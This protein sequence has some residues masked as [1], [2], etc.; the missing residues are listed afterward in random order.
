MNRKSNLIDS[1]ESSSFN[2]ESLQN[3]GKDKGFTSTKRQ[4]FIFGPHSLY[5]CNFDLKAC[6]H[7]IWY[8][9]FK[10]YSRKARFY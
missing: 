6:F 4:N 9:P 1:E 3:S 5:F 10:C 7:E 2:Q 8:L